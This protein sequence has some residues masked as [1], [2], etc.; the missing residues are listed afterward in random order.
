MGNQQKTRD[1]LLKLYE[2]MQ[3]IR[4]FEETTSVMNKAGEIPGQVHLYIGEEAVA[5]GIC[6]HLSKEDIITSTHRGHGHA[7][8]KGS[9]SDRCMAELY[10]RQ[11]GYC[12]GRGG[13]MHIY[14]LGNGL[15]GTNGIVGG[16]IPLALGAALTFRNQK[17]DRVG[18]TFFGDGA[19]NM[20]IFYESMNLAAI[21]HLPVVFICENNM[22]A[23]AIPIT[24]SASNPEIATKAAAF[25]IPGVVVD[26]N[27][28]LAVYDAAGE[29]IERARKGDGPSLI[30]AK[31]YR[32]HGHNE[33]EPLYG[34]Y[35]TAE[36]V[37]AWKLKC[38]I[39]NYK[40]R[41]LE[42]FKFRENEIEEIDAR[43]QKEIADAVE[44]SRKS[45]LPEV[46]DI[47][48]HVFTEVS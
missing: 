11:D 39:V 45:P 14:D 16:G 3:R 24:Y 36:E 46:A 22:Y 40:R 12:G 35:R 20:G 47:K 43:I 19:S 23:T 41:L 48:K 9:H 4:V 33:G 37:E 26:G 2:T 25:K 7:L 5:A 28:V 10:G 17:R 34:T 6:A 31:T 1:I 21:Y 38:P 29:A 44:F 30:E 13:S 8:A 18:I 15:L 27:D 42:E 32:T